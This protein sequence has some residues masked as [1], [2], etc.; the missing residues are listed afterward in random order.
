MPLE[1]QGRRGGMPMTRSLSNVTRNQVPTE[2]SSVSLGHSSGGAKAESSDLAF[3][4]K[5]FKEIEKVSLNYSVLLP[6]VQCDTLATCSG[7]GPPSE[8]CSLL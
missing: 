6:R 3:V 8:F 1:A 5:N 4:L 7:R 2:T